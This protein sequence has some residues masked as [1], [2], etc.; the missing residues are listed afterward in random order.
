MNRDILVDRKKDSLLKG[1]V[2]R[3]CKSV[4]LWQE[5]GRTSKMYMLHSC[6]CCRTVRIIKDEGKAYRS[7]KKLF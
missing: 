6:K 4:G 2:C 1:T 7:L 3:V 5:I